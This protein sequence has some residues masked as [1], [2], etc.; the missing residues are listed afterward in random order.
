[1]K[2]LYNTKQGTWVKLKYPLTTKEGYK[3]KNLFFHEIEGIFARLSSTG[4]E[5]FKT[6]A[7]SK[8]EDV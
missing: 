4:G 7:V 2:N 6:L 5:Q 1:M 8:V 3:V